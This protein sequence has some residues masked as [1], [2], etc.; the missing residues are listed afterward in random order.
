MRKSQVLWTLLTSSALVAPAFAADI[1]VKAPSAE[2]QQVSG[3]LEMEGG[4]AWQ[5]NRG[6]NPFQSNRLGFD[7]GYSGRDNKWMANGAARVNVWWVRNYS[8]QFDVWGGLDS[9]GRT[10]GNNNGVIANVNL[11]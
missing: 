1:P 4:F 2:W 7:I 8:T 3:Y 6:G 10:N 5:D 11:G 9:F